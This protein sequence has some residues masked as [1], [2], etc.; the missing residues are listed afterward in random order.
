MY[1]QVV[2]KYIFKYMYILHIAKLLVLLSIDLLSPI[3]YLLPLVCAPPSL[4]GRKSIRPELHGADMDGLDM[5]G[6]AQVDE[7]CI[8]RLGMNGAAE[9]STELDTGGGV[10]EDK[11]AEGCGWDVWE[12]VVSAWLDPLLDEVRNSR[13]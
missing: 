1:I 13:V 4:V 7:I 12:R 9:R 11:G 8:G 2:Y 3:L 5:D 6:G 10:S